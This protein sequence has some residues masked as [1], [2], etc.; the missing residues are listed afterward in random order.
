MLQFEHHTLIIAAAIVLSLLL[1]LFIYRKDARFRSAGTFLKI[2]LVGLRF[3][4]LSILAL[5]LFKPKWLNET[6][7]VEKPIIVFLQ[8]A[9]S[10]ILNYPD[11]T[12]YESEFIKLIEKNNRTLSEEFELYSYHF[13]ESVKEGISNTYEGKST[14]ISNAFQNIDDRFHNRNLAA[15]ILASDGNYNKGVNPYYQTAELNCPIFT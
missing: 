9:S 13:S 1:A 12:F 11:S 10:S 3:I 15:I 4:S 2:L 5:L 14:D 7:E 6:K 8:D